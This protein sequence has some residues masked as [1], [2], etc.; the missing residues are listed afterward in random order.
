MFKILEVGVCVMPM[1]RA[2][3]PLLAHA[4]MP[5]LSRFLALWLPRS[6]GGKEPRLTALILP[7]RRGIVKSVIASLSIVR[8]QHNIGRGAKGHFMYRTSLSRVLVPFGGN[9]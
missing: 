1:T 9:K 2:R 8:K 6:L 3:L 7:N 4:P 5:S